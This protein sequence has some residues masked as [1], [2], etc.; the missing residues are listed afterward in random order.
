MDETENLGSKPVLNNNLASL[1][2]RLAA[3]LLDGVL[4]IIIIFL[5]LIIIFGF[6]G[7]KELMV[8]YGLLYFFIMLLISQCVYLL[9]NGRL[10]YKY[11]QTI[12]KR[13]LEIKIVSIENELPKFYTSYGLRYAVTILFNFIPIIGNYLYLV[14]ILFIFRKNRRCIHDLIAGKKVIEA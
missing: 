14:D 11:G 8:K 3:S 2:D 6:S 1:S 12:G 9:L 4:L 5:P 7:I 10:L 13:Y